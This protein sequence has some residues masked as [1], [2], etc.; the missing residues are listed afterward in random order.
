MKKI[1]IFGEN[2]S[3]KYDKIRVACRGI[4]I[5]GCEILLSYE[6]VTDQWMLPGG[7][8]EENESLTECCVREIEEETGFLVQPSEC[9]LEID[10]YYEN[11]RFISY[12]F[13]C[14]ITG[15]TERKLTEREKPFGLEPRWLSIN[16]VMD[17]FSKHNSFYGVNEERRGLYLR[18]YTAFSELFTIEKGVI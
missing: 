7:G 18:E 16:T 2:Y 15:T 1:D 8:V 13:F 4:I 3:G 6:T 9:A 14:T 10:E 12:Y 17:I 11:V 5:K